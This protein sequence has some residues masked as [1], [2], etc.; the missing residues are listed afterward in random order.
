MTMIESVL[1]R[2]GAVGL[3]LAMIVGLTVSGGALPAVAASAPG[4]PSGITVITGDKAAR[5]TWV[6]PSDTGGSPITG[7]TATASPGGR[8]CSTAGDLT[9]RIDGLTNGKSYTFAV[10]ATNASGTSAPSAPSA[11]ITLSFAPGGA[12]ASI[13]VN[14]KAQCTSGKPVLAV[15]VL[16]K[17]SVPV[18]ARVTTSLGEQNIAELAAGA[19]QYLTFPSPADALPAG[20]TTI[21]ASKTV[22]AV[23]STS[24]YEAAYTAVNCDTAG[25]DIT[26]TVAP[27]ANAFGW[28]NTDVAV[29]FSCTDSSGVA[30][31]AGDTTLT[32]EGLGQT[33][34]GDAVDAQGNHSSSVVGPINIDKTAPTLVGAPTTTP[35]AAGWFNG[36]VTVTWTGDD[37]LSGLD[38]ATQPADSRVTGEGGNL[39]AG[40]VT[41]ADKAGNTSAPASVTGIKIDRTA[42]VI[43]GRPTTTPN[44]DGWYRTAV[45]VDFTCTDAVSGVAQC[46]TSA[47]VGTDGANQSVTSGAGRDLADNTSTATVAGLNIDASAPST[48]SNNQCVKANG[49]CTGSSA[50]VVLTATDQTGLSGV[51]EIRYR[52]GG[53]S[54]QVT[55]GSSASVTVPLDGSGNATV[56][57]WAVDKAGNTE[58]PNT[59]ALDYD[60]IAPT[61]THTVSPAANA[62]GWN[63]STVVVHFDAKDDDSGS[64]LVPG[65]ITGDVTVSAETAGQ[66]VT[67]SATD[68]AGNTGTDT[69]TVKLDRT[70]PTITAAASGGT[71]GS[72]GWYTGPVTV[73]FTCT[74]ILSGIASCPD[75]VVLTGNGTSNQAAGTTTDKAGNTASATLSGIK[76]DQEKP[77]LTKA[78]INVEGG[79]YVL[80]AV[81]TASC[82]A[83]DTLSGLASCNVTISGG[84]SNGVGTFTY[85]AVAKDKAGNTTTVTGTYRVIYFFLGFL[86]PVID[87]YPL[88]PIVS[89]YKSGSTLPLRFMLLNANG[90]IVQATTAP[91]WLTPTKGSVTSAWTIPGAFPASTPDTGTTYR[92]D[93]G[94]QTYQYNWKAV[95]AGYYWRIGATLD[96]GQTYYAT[97]GLR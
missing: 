91:T 81:P 83:T 37:G 3:V 41:I 84:K 15:Y 25:P 50:T 23:T 51:K 60:N 28:N 89:V 92:F 46:P 76:I 97:I 13:S 59:A 48:T 39:T 49:Y 45:T 33:V 74:D 94:S 77:K 1:K 36:D 56:T 47:V 11:P 62:N 18:T 30:G 68:T 87:L 6:A 58:S 57:Y 32:N 88:L 86:P 34:S 31:C 52:V 63:N 93:T 75:D 95:G 96:D 24:S 8:S 20:M 65:S 27:P 2:L 44:A 82:K 61:V 80:G 29:T 40:P 79:T 70:A 53:G 54:E 66:L 7:Y 43:T 71:L 21:V 26:A 78:D 22:N 85:T 9:C 73:H 4:A 90:G 64:G 10:T 35:N 55:T 17:E 69:V 38:P 72:N 16:N 5:V 42:P 12:N 19:P 67:G 14:A